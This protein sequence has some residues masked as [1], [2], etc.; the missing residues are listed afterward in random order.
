MCCATTVA[1]SAYG[2]KLDTHRVPC[3]H[4]CCHPPSS[5]RRAFRLGHGDM[6]LRHAAAG[7]LP[8]RLM[9]APQKCV[10]F[11][12]FVAWRG[13]TENCLL[14]SVY[15]TLVFR[16]LRR[17]VWLG[18][19]ASFNAGASFQHPEPP[20]IDHLRTGGSY[21][22]LQSACFAHYLHS[23]HSAPGR[24][25]IGLG[26]VMNEADVT[27]ALDLARV[28]FGSCP[29]VAVNCAGIGYAK[30]T[31]S[32]W[33]FSHSSALLVGLPRSQT[34]YGIPTVADAR[35][36]QLRSA[37]RTDELSVVGETDS[38]VGNVPYASVRGGRR[39]ASV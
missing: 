35:V 33:L 24:C 14:F 3:V 39:A 22:L 18:G 20:I 25:S 37:A 38:A 11:F 32:R 9:F 26:Q 8:S 2:E 31:I 27:R 23:Y 17:L 34:S 12:S 29:F 36:R 16:L 5:K 28:E 21:F 1:V 6:L 19:S 4:C 7:N 13:C 10:R 15:K 30:R